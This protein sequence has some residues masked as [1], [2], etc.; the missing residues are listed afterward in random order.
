MRTVIH[1]E[2]DGLIWRDDK[3]LYFHKSPNLKTKRIRMVL[4]LHKNGGVSKTATLVKK[5]D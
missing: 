5:L 1:I 2:H 4:M 3:N